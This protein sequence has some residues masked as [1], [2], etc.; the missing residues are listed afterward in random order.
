MLA[1]KRSRLPT[2]FRNP[3]AMRFAPSLLDEM[4]NWP[5]YGWTTDVPLA[6]FYETDD[7]FFVELDLPGFE[8]DNI[9]VTVE[10]GALTITGE[11]P[12]IE[13]K[14]DFHLRERSFERFT[15]TFTLPRAIDPA[16]VESFIHNGVLKIVMPKAPEAVAKKIEV[17]VK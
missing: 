6:D 5:E 14:V 3:A 11:R 17:T 1:T 16:K 9:N 7:A 13:E 12:M 15:R 2:L 10:R 4:F 8:R